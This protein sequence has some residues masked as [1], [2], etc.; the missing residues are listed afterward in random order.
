MGF[1]GTIEK[2]Y[3]KGTVKSLTQ[4]PVE[5]LKATPNKVEFNRYTGRDTQRYILLRK[6]GTDNFLFYNYTPTEETKVFQDVPDS[7]KS[8]K[9]VKL[10]KLDPAHRQDKEVWAPKLDGAHNLIVLRGGKTPDIFSYRK[11]R[12]GPERIDHTYRTEAYKEVIPEEFK[13]TI[14]RGELYT[15]GHPGEQTA[16]LL[17]SNVWK[18]REIQSKESR[19]LSVAAF[20]VVKWKGKNVEDLPFSEKLPMLDEIKRKL[21]T[22]GVPPFARTKEEKEELQKAIFEQRHPLTDEGIVV[23]DLDSPTPRKSKKRLDWDAEIVGVFPAA[24][25]SKYHNNGIGG[26]IV[27][28][29]N[30]NIK[31]KVGS[32]LDDQLRRDAYQNPEKYIGEWAEFK[33]QRR[34]TSGMHQAPIFKRIRMDKFEKIAFDLSDSSLSKDKKYVTQHHS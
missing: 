31:L 27:K 12:R 19:P 13:K 32:G 17:N 4:E 9:T 15:P 14:L 30:S 7:K 33:S 23:Y 20:D 22:I 24:P 10:E 1:S 2:G 3:G 25:D 8:Y 34:H 28:P 21:N 6:P 5:V 16:R 26:F 18:S 11:S 29:E